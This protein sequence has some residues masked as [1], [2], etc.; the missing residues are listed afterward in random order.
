[1]MLN[2]FQGS[3]LLISLV[4]IVFSC[5]KEEVTPLVYYSRCNKDIQYASN[6]DTGGFIKELSL[7]LYYPPE[8]LKSSK[9]PLVVV[10]HGGSFQV[11]S[12]ETMTD[13]CRR[14]S[15]SG[16]IAACINY[17][18]GWNDTEGCQSDPIELQKAVYRGMQD[19]NAALRFLVSNDE[20]Y[21]IDTNWIFIGGYSAGASIALN[22]SYS[23]DSYIEMHCPELSSQLGGLKNSGNLLSNNYIIKGIFN[24]WGAICDSGLIT[25][26]NAIST[27]SFHGQL[28]NLVSADIGHFLGCSGF[29][30]YYGSLCIHR[31]LVKFS[32]PVITHVLSD[33]GH[34]PL[35]EFT[36]PFMAADVACFFH[37]LM[38]GNA[39]SGLYTGVISSCR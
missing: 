22:C 20:Q 11:G 4:L 19:A 3:L 17:R 32:V 18:L 33:A 38:K 6:V 37:H 16:F 30:V 39:G 35:D 13:L 24:A 5:T 9:F 31:Q 1:M 15:D 28:D 36:T 8:A 27:I 23:S 14:L 2:R 25:Q 34:E 21:S 10:L 7:D 26:A 29:P 12:K